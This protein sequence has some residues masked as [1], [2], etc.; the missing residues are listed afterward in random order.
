MDPTNSLGQ[1]PS[2]SRAPMA[3][4]LLTL[5]GFVL[6]AGF[7]TAALDEKPPPLDK[8]RWGCLALSGAILCSALLGGASRWATTL[9]G[10]TVLMSVIVVVLAAYARHNG[11]ENERI[12]AEPTWWPQFERDLREYVRL[13]SAGER[14]D[15]SY[16]AS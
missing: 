14:R 9:S 1:P 13:G 7:F 16:R 6:S 4:E 11:S 3:I 8:T 10:L 2:M 5:G 12:A 15:D